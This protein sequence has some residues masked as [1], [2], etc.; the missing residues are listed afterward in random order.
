MKKKLNNNR[1]VTLVELLV[2]LALITITLAVVTNIFV[3]GNKTFVT[4]VD[5]STVQQDG[6][7]TS[8]RIADELKFAKE[9]KASA[10]EIG[11]KTTNGYYR[12]RL[13]DN[14][15]LT[16]TEKVLEIQKFDSTDTE[17]PNTMQKVGRYLVNIKYTAPTGSKIVKYDIDVTTGEQDF[18]INSSVKS[19]NIDTINIGTDITEIYYT[20]YP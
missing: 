13:V 18:T 17:V 5:K 6:R 14:P 2:A 7:F 9:I 10:A 8:D 16:G 12:M 20:L 11:D 4:G 3:V 1:G 15:D 19:M